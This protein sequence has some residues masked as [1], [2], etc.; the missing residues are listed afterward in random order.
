MSVHGDDGLAV[1]SPLAG[2]CDHLED[3]PDPV[4]SGR[5][6]GDGV[7][8]DPTVGE[9]VAPF[10][11][12]VLNVPDSRHALNLRADN[13]A[14]LLLHVGIDTVTLAGEGFDCLVG[15]GERIT[16]G[17]PLLRF[18]L[19][20]LARRAPSL[21]TPVLLLDAPGRSLRKVRTPGP[22]VPGDVLFEVVCANVATEALPVDE[23]AAGVERALRVG[24]EHGLHARPAAGL[25]AA[26]A[27][28]D[29]RVRLH[30]TSG[31]QA[32]ANSP[33]ALMGLGL[34]RGDTVRIVARGPDANAAVEVLSSLLEPLASDPD[35]VWVPSPHR[36]EPPGADTRLPGLAASAGLATGTAA[37]L[38]A[39]LPP[40]DATAPDAVAE[41]QA[42]DEAMDAV[43]RHLQSLA[44][45]ASSAA[46]EVAGAHLALLEDPGLRERAGA[47]MEAGR[48]A[49]AAWHTATGEAA[50]TLA[51]LDDP[52]LRERVDDLRDLGG[53]VVRVLAGQAPGYAQE[54]PPDAIL[55][56]DNLLPSQ[57][58]AVGD[59]P[60]AGI[61]LA[62]GGATSHVAILAAAR[63]IPMLVA[64]G[65]SVTAITA[66]TPLCLDAEHGE[67]WVDPPAD[68]LRRFR[69]RVAYEARLDVAARVR[70]TEPCETTDGVRVSV[71]ANL[72]GVDEAEAAL[73]AGAEGCGLLRSEFLYMARNSAPGVATQRREVQ[74]V[75]DVLGDRPLVVRTLD[76]GADKPIAYLDQVAEENP[77][78]GVRGIR[79]GLARPELLDRQ[80]EALLR[81]EHA[82]PLQVMLP[83]VARIDEVDRVRERI[84]HL[85]QAHGLD[86]PLSLGVMIETP[87]AA[88][89]ADRLAER[90]DFFSIGTNDLAQYTLC[91]DRVAPAL[92]RQ[93]DAL[94]PA[95]LSLVHFTAQAA[96]RAGIE[97]SVCG[98]A[99]GDLEAAPVLLGLGVSKLSMAPAR[100]ARIKA[101]LRGVSRAQCRDLAQQALTGDSAGQVR[102]LVRTTLAGKK[103][104]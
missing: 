43:K 90:V 104:Q 62:G 93:L 73:H 45:G 60:L 49:A 103:E 76:A 64:A 12:Q 24:L 83:M 22:V 67:L 38:E 46:A 8:I 3:L 91:M 2:W 16:A 14:E 42:L 77:A 23:P 85:R 27:A 95:V 96:E 75:S 63:G 87:A 78:L 30:A 72:A 97:V 29:A 28:L 4:F 56:A 11:G 52:R 48:S 35:P 100:V 70:A 9:L 37:L 88:L 74:S 80:L 92:A 79:L 47:L 17:Q 26:L 25:V 50:Q 20:L 55:L 58:M 98:A 53:Q 99:A 13:G 69:E 82:R 31:A 5:V 66:G 7:S 21:R 10:D 59:E 33:V 102:D 65:A 81:V 61:C 54:L 86:R 84:E 1:R 41:R 94:D 19:E 36:I 18:D 32:D 71:L 39:D 68:A 51:A 34:V 44:G 57:L 40:F 101:L 6:L 89:L 15:P